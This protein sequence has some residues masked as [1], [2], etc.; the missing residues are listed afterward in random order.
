M[1]V[2]EPARLVRHAKPTALIVVSELRAAEALMK[3]LVARGCNV[4]VATTC[5]EVRALLETQVFE[6]VLSPVRLPD[7]S[8]YKLMPLVIGKPTT[9]AFL[10]TVQDGAWWLPAVE[11]GRECFGQC[12]LRPSEFAT[13]LDAILHDASTAPDQRKAAA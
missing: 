1:K 8:V 12:A 4:R 9:L 3:R 10:F 11:K 5:R 7:G 6:V 13:M 2:T